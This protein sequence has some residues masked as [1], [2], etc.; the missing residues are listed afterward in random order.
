MNYLKNQRR[1][2]VDVALEF[3]LMGYLRLVKLQNDLFLCRNCSS[4]AAARLTCNLL[5][6]HGLGDKCVNDQEDFWTY[7]NGFLFADANEAFVVEN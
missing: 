6:E 3:G 7:E 4:C 2:V 5:K 1:N